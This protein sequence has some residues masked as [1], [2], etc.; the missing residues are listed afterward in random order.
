MM[1]QENGLSELTVFEDPHNE[2][3]LGSVEKCNQTE[4]EPR[5]PYRGAV[6][7]CLEVFRNLQILL[8]NR[9]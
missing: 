8:R 3:P 2:K 9:T 6:E 1:A 5:V 4:A 7:A